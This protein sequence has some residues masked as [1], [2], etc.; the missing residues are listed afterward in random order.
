MSLRS[1]ICEKSETKASLELYTDQVLENYDRPG[2][3][4][5]ES[6]EYDP[7]FIKV[8]TKPGSEE[9]PSDILHI[10]K[11]LSSESNI[12]AMAEDKQGGCFCR[13]KLIKTSQR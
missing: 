11:T 10:T 3:R 8:K 2:R 12:I 4:L 13:L 6:I 9:I 5:L 7:V 1:S